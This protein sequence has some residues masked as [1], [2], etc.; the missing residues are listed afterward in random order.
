M[1]E[2][3]GLSQGVAGVPGAAGSRSAPPPP[4]ATVTGRVSVECLGCE[5]TV[6]LLGD[7]KMSSLCQRCA[8]HKSVASYWDRAV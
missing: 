2:L 7:H 6:R 8:A 1:T 4:T 5:D 3:S